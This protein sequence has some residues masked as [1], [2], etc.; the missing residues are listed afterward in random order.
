MYNYLITSFFLLLTFSINAQNLLTNPDYADESITKQQLNAP[1]FQKVLEHQS[2]AQLEVQLFEVAETQQKIQDQL[3]EAIE[4]GILLNINEQ[5]ANQMLIQ[6]PTFIQLAIPVKNSKLLELDLYQVDVLSEN[7]F[8]ET[9]DGR[10]LEA[11]NGVY[12][13]GVVKNDPSSIVAISIFENQIQGIISNQTGN[14]NLGKLPDNSGQYVFYNDQQLKPSNPFTCQ[15]DDYQMKLKP[16]V[17]SNSPQEKMA[18]CVEIYIEA[19]FSIYQDHNSNTTTVNTYLAAL[20]VQV[21][22]VYS[23]E[24]INIALSSTFVWT[25]TDPYV[26]MNAGTVL[27]EWAQDRQNAYTGRLAHFVS[28]RNMGG[29]AWLG[30]LCSQYFTFN[31]D[32]DGDGVAEPHYAGPYGVSSGL[33]KN[34]VT[35]PNYSWSVNVLAHELGHNFG[36]E[37]THACVWGANNNEALDNCSPVEGGNC[38]PGPT[39]SNGGTIMSYCHT[40]GV[41]INFNNGF[42]A[43]PGNKIRDNYNNANCTLTCANGPTGPANDMC[44]GAVNITCGQSLVSTT[45]DATSTDD[46]GTCVIGAAVNAVWFTFRGTGGDVTFSTCSNNTTFNTRMHVYQGDCNNIVCV[47]GNEDG[48]SCSNGQSEITISTGAGV[49]YYILVSGNSSAGGNFE[50]TAECAHDNCAGAIPVN[51]GD[52]VQGSNV[53]A[54][55][56]GDPTGTCVE[57]VDGAG[58]WYVLSNVSGPV[59]ISTCNAFTNYDSKLHAYSNSCGS[60]TCVAGNDD[61]QAC[62]PTQRSLLEFTASAGTDYYIFV[63]GWNG[64]IG[65]FQLDISCTSTSNCQT[66]ITQSGS[67]TGDLYE[68]QDWILSTGT[69]AAP[70]QVTYHAGN[71][72]E[73]N[74]NFAVDTGADFLAEIQA[75]SPLTS[76]ETKSLENGKSITSFNYNYHAETDKLVYKFFIKN[77]QPTQM[78]LC[79]EKGTEQQY[80]VDSQSQ[81]MVQSKLDC[82]ALSGGWYMLKLSNGTISIEQKVY[83]GK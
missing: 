56:T 67:I 22:A 6:K 15:T 81:K 45:V 30:V 26:N 27:E 68:A 70:E 46:P 5:I 8:M 66:N 75:C 25:S 4:D 49:T 7:Y 39:P 18:D 14:Y 10:M 53:A 77:D 71:Y 34:V 73:L 43:E 82:S 3:N 80:E 21:A 16:A 24:N 79:N 38:S 12:Y 31:A 69:I 60:L 33:S 51:C 13:H 9:S 54:N 11:P 40:T 50:I 59:S 61:D 23:A 47:D 17:D 19:D 41:G 32:F 52:S 65:D 35:V 37:H 57:S 28:K 20:M 42:G 74:N 36:S 58:V 55:A 44:S 62:S 48:P 64:N 2:T 29:I 63:S 83:I 76:S 72:I 78:S 1:I